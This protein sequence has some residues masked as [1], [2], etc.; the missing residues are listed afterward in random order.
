MKP[1]TKAAAT[2]MAAALTAAALF[3]ASAG[4]AKS[5]VARLAILQTTDLHGYI[6][7]NEES[8]GVLKLA[9]LIKREYEPGKTLLIDC[10]DTFEGSFETAQTRGEIMLP[11][12]NALPYDAWVPYQN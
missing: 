10:G 3:S 8:P 12:M 9:S 6:L 11:V 7:P 2:V 1:F 4:D 5:S